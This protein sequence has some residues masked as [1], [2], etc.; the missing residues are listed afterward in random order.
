MSRTIAVVEFDETPELREFEQKLAQNEQEQ[1][2]LKTQYPNLDRE[3]T[4]FSAT[5]GQPDALMIFQAL[6]HHAQR[7]ANVEGID[8]RLTRVKEEFA[9]ISPTN[10]GKCARMLE[11]FLNSR[12]E[13]RK[14]L[15][16]LERERNALIENRSRIIP[17]CLRNYRRL[18]EV[19]LMSL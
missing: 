10:A 9:K 6:E 3:L 4:L 7:W 18:K 5:D 15:D 1:N 16:R 13:A 8:G 11:D 12:Q 19:I 2:K 17:Q 14:E